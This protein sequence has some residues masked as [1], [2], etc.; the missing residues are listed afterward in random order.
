MA[1]IETA[2][3]RIE[4][5]TVYR[6]GALIK[7]R[8]RGR[9]RLQ[10]R[11]LPLLFS[12]DTLRVRPALGS[13]RDLEETVLLQS[14]PA[15][16][17][18]SEEEKAELVLQIAQAD[19][20]IRSCAALAEAAGRLVPVLPDARVPATLPDPARFAELLALADHQRADA[21][22]RKAAAERKKRALER[23]K[24]KLAARNVGE[25]EPP[26]ILR[27]AQFSLDVSEVVDFELEYF[28]HA[29]RWVPTY[30]LHLDGGR[31]RLVVSALVAQATGEDWSGVTLAV[32]TADLLRE[33]TLPTLGSWRMSRAQPPAA[34]GFRP[35]P[36]DLP[37]LFWGY[38]KQPRRPATPSAPP[39]PPPAEPR[40]FERA[41]TEEVHSFEAERTDNVAVLSLQRDDSAAPELLEDDGGDDEVALDGAPADAGAAFAEEKTLPTP[42]EE[43]FIRPAQ[44]PARRAMAAPSIESAASGMVAPAAPMGK[45]SP[46]K[47]RAG[48]GGALSARAHVELPPRWRT[49]YLRMCGPDE[50]RR[51][52]LVALDP[53]ERLE[54]LL[55]A[56]DLEGEGERATGRAELRRAV[57]ALQTAQQRLQHAPLPR[58]TAALLGTHFPSVLVAAGSTDVPGDGAFYRVAVRTDEG[59]A[60]IEHRAVPR[61][62]N[63]VWRFCRLDVK[64]PPLPAGP[65]AVYE[66][67]AFRVN[68]HLQ[69]TGGGK[70]LDVN[71][72]VEPDVRVVTRTVHVNQAEKGLMSQTSRVEHQL[73]LEIRSTRAKPVN[74][75]VWDR[76]P[77][78]ADNVKD[79]SVQLVEERP[80]AKRTN[81][82]AAGADVV[83]ALEWHL[84][85][86]PG[87]TA[88][89]DYK[90]VIDLP[91]KAELEGGNRRE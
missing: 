43:M 51:G 84:T 89:I 31:A 78:P 75:V 54:W 42:H 28:V 77:T 80:P 70:V 6:N 69:G 26:R 37:T 16:L 4:Q 3:T 62:A 24:H 11:G 60:R 88:R 21:L 8:G 76:L 17:P 53:M 52:S 35:L 25:R 65:L 67:G 87:E 29:A 34:R 36:S 23:D 79:V 56:H 14:T 33:T 22:E 19:D 41:N 72:G 58:G 68:A 50:A 44:A 90:Y 55:E 74:L 12:S 9:G 66:D 91:A 85:V 27:G 61:A 45:P 48:G 71:L 13:V 30:A 81:K 32:S 86:M 57:D 73:H 46:S 10:V 15:P 40:Q 1:T 38:D 49:A 5:V 20:E 18:A 59:A 39:P 2:S 63:D 83:G 47:A 7:R 64:G 82:D